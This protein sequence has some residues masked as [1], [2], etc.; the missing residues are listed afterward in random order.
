[1]SH[2]YVDI[3]AINN[4]PDKK[5]QE[6]IFNQIKSNNIIN[7]VSKYYIS[8]VRWSLSSN[9]PQ[10][11]PELKLAASETPYTGELDYKI[12]LLFGT[13]K[14][15]L[16]VTPGISKSLYFENEDI[17]L[18]APVNQPRTIN[19]YIDNEYFYIY[20]I[21]NFLTMLNKALKECFDD[22]K[23]FYNPTYNNTSLYQA[24]K[25]VWND[26]YNKIDLYI[27]EGFIQ[28]EGGSNN[29]YISMNTNLFNLF[30]T[31]PSCNLG[32]NIEVNETQG[33]A[34]LLYTRQEYQPFISTTISGGVNLNLYIYTQNSSSV[35]SWCPCNSIRF[36]S[37][38]LSI[39]PSITGAPYYIGNSLKDNES[40][41]AISTILTD[42]QI[43]MTIGTEY[44]R[45]LLYYVPQSEYRLFNLIGQGNIQNINISVEWLD[46][47]GFSHPFK[48]KYGSMASIKLLLREKKFNY[49]N[50]N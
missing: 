50:D 24:P 45:N 23:T 1:M 10:I 43:P 31:F 48:I 29:L 38:T 7:D 25:F 26:N 35:T 27:S 36:L 46:N 22:F 11:I 17:T 14:D 16:T 49:N 33:R 4:S 40:V 44:S 41:N 42:F 6:V 39:N 34:Y 5:P 28:E 32:S 20:S 12:N 30:N 47:Y 18:Q 13:D 8:C 21:D 15:N 3:I 37:H 2:E 19:E 9:I